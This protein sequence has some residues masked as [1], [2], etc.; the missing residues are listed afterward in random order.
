MALSIRFDSVGYQYLGHT[1]LYRP[2]ALPL[3]VLIIFVKDLQFLCLTN[4]TLVVPSN[5]LF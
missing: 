2:C 1:D 4:L 5:L 3:T